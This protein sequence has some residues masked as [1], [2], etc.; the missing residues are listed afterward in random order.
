M[1]DDDELFSWK[2]FEVG[3]LDSNR[4]HQIDDAE[5]RQV[6]KYLPSPANTELEQK[7]DADG[8]GWLESEETRKILFRRIESIFM[9]NGREA[10]KTG[11]EKLY[12]TNQDGVI[13]LE[14]L[15][16]LREDLK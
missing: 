9:T 16:S 4:D 1:L 10:I 15:K 14:E 5:K 13:D 2:D 3:R 12:D 11:L 8:N 6:W 7:F